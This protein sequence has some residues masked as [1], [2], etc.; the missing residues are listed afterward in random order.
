LKDQ[1]LCMCNRCADGRINVAKTNGMSG[2]D[3]APFIFG[4]MAAPLSLPVNGKPVGH[5]VSILNFLDVAKATG[6]EG[7][8]AQ[9][10][11]FDCKGVQLIWEHAKAAKEN[12]Q[13]HHEALLEPYVAYVAKIKDVQGLDEA[14]KI[15]L[16]IVT[17]ILVDINHALQNDGIAQAVSSAVAGDIHAPRMHLFAYLEDVTKDPRPLYIF[18]PKQKRFV[19]GAPLF[20][21]M[22]GDRKA[23]EHYRITAAIDI[24]HFIAAEATRMQHADLNGLAKRLVAVRPTQ[25]TQPV[26]RRVR[27]RF[28]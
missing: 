25:Q 26:A 17:K 6:R 23:L 21:Q 22:M 15:H 20:A 1:F 18:D 2:Y 9:W 8:F 13:P 28:G 27:Q 3:T 24:D 12:L 19:E 5:I 10:G 11:H 14:A 16:L 4:D 7:F